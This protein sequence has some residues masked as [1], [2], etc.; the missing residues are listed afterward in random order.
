[1][2]GALEGFFD[3]LDGQMDRPVDAELMAAAVRCCRADGVTEEN[4]FIPS[5][6]IGS[7]SAVVR[8]TQGS[9]CVGGRFIET[10]AP[11]D[12]VAPAVTGDYDVVLVCDDSSAVRAFRAECRIRGSYQSGNGIYYLTLGR[13]SCIGNGSIFTTME[14]VRVRSPRPL[15]G[16][17]TPVFSTALNPADITNSFGYYIKSGNVVTAYFRAHASFGASAPVKISGL[18]F[19]AVSPGGKTVNSA[20]L[21]CW[22]TVEVDGT[23]A[24]D[25]G[26]VL[27][28]TLRINMT[29]SPQTIDLYTKKYVETTG[30][31]FVTMPTW[32][33]ADSYL[34]VWGS[35]SYVTNQ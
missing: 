17:W 9:A 1:M 25:P 11:I 4:D 31:Q 20:N 6:E 22:S 7:D 10:S 24:Q 19:P 29:A 16:Y 8:L 23:M 12:I 3:S 28:H 5:F 27:G 34:N 15:K 21:G 35:I 14:D 2:N 13:F 18:P 30:Y 26:N 33:M 32:S